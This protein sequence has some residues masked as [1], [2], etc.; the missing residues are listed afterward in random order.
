MLPKFKALW[1][2]LDYIWQTMQNWKM[3]G[4]IRIFENVGKIE[5]CNGK[6]G[7]KIEKQEKFNRK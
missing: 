4:K 2:A 5:K 1:K 3:G 7:G 6:I